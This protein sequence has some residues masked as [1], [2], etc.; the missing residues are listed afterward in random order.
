MKKILLAAGDRHGLLKVLPLYKALHEHDDYEAVLA[1]GTPLPEG[2]RSGEKL[3]GLFGVSER[4]VRIDAGGDT[5]V[6]RTASAMNVFGELLAS[7]KPDLAVIAGDDDISLAAALAAAKLSLPV[8]SVGAGLRDYNRRS[9]SEINR[10]LIDSVTDI[11]FVSEHSGEYNLISEGFDEDRIFF[12]GE[13]LIDSLAAVV[14][15]SNSSTVVDDLGLRA[16]KYI[17]VM[18]D[19]A[20]SLDSL[21]ALKNIE[22]VVKAIAEKK[23]VLM[24]LGPDVAAVLR[25]HEMEPAFTSV[26][27]VQVRPSA[28]YVELLCLVKDALFIL[29]DSSLGQAESTV[30][31]VPCLTMLDDTTSPATIEIGTN[32]L[33]G[34]REED[35]LQAVDKA[36]QGDFARRAVIPEKWDGAAS[37]R[38]VDVLDRVL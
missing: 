27:G 35:I 15:R 37:Q 9:S 29:T 18:L 6:N 10:V 1:A 14:A 8:A 16:K 28:A 12:V 26:P 36:F 11:L 38:I 2:E 30:M 24:L 33:V 5:P 19:Q 34:D 4:V 22:R 17:L 20:A 25:E 13:L 31:K 3:P 23:P 7:E 21:A 32:T